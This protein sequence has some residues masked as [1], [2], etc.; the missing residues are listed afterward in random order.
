[1]K[2][3]LFMYCTMGRKHELEA[4]LAGLNNDYYQR[5]L[6]EIREIAQFAIACSNAAYAALPN[7]EACKN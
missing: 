6:E 4:G 7:T 2:F 3:D 5:M 1:M